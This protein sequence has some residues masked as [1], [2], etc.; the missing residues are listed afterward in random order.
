MTLTSHHPRAGTKLSSFQD[1]LK[2]SLNYNSNVGVLLLVSKKSLKRISLGI[3]PT[4]SARICFLVFIYLFTYSWK[5]HF[6][7]NHTPGR[8][9]EIWIK[10]IIC[11]EAQKS[12]GRY[13]RA[14]KLI[15]RFSF[16]G[17]V[18]WCCGSQEKG[19]LTQVWTQEHSPEGVKCH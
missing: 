5:S 19:H 3:V 14:I 2:M 11:L 17:V 1:G 16:H 12:Y 4:A 18:H 6:N 13:R 10:P 7:T 8:M 9:L 15:I